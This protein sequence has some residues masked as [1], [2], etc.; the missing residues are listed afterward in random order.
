M[1][2]FR[3]Q[4]GNTLRVSS[5]RFSNGMS[6]QI[7]LGGHS[8][9]SLEGSLSGNHDEEKKSKGSCIYA[10]GSHEYQA[11]CTKHD[12]AFADVSMFDVFD[13][14]LHMNVHAF[15]DY[16]YAMGRSITVMGRSIT[17]YGFM[18]QECAV[19]WEAMLRHMMAL[20]TTEA[21]YMT[22]TRGLKEDTW[23]KGLSTESG[24]ELRLVA[25]IAT[26]ALTKA[27]P[28]PRFQHWLK[29]LRIGEG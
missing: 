25:D 26:G 24:F 21:K 10:V 16:D 27:V 28:G 15:V 2:I 9:L 12:I 3:T 5:F 18:I 1:E 7:L 6:V 29:L 8:T 22:L 14:G 11:F 4:S 13:R 23:L 19:S 20:L 17:T